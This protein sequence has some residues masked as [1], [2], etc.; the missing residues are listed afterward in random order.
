M[1]TET[2]H[3][4]YRETR[5]GTLDIDGEGRHRYVPCRETTD[6][7]ASRVPLLSLRFFLEGQDFGPPEP[8]LRFRI[9]RMKQFGFT[10]HGFVQDGMAL[11]RVFPE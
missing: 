8:T 11:K 2:Y 1:I 6:A 3:V 9:E 10:E 5:I 4:F 7:L